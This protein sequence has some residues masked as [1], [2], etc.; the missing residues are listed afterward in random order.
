MQVDVIWEESLKK[1]RLI[2]EVSF[3]DNTN[4]KTFDSLKD[5]LDSIKDICSA[6]NFPANPTNPI[7]KDNSN[8]EH[9]KN[10]LK[11][12]NTI[13]KLNLSNNQ[14][15]PEGAIAIAAALKDNKT[16]TTLGLHNNQIGPE[17]AIAI[18]TALKDKAITGLYLGNNQIGD[19][20]AIAIAAA[21]KD[22][23]AITKLGLLNNQIGP[24]GAKAIAAVLK[25]NKTI[26]TLSLGNNKIGDEGAI[27]IA[28]AL[29]DNKIITGLYLYDN[30]IGDEGAKALAAVLKDNKAITK[31][32]LSNNQIGDEGAI[33]IATALKD[34]KTIT[35]LNLERNKIGDKG[36]KALAAALKDNKNIKIIGL[37]I[38]QAKDNQKSKLTSADIK[39]INKLWAN[40][41]IEIAKAAKDAKTAKAFED[42][43][44]KVFRSSSLD[45]N[46]K[47][48]IYKAYNSCKDSL[49]NL[50]IKELT[51]IEKN[52]KYFLAGGFIT[53][54]TTLILIL[55]EIQPRL[56][57][58]DK[59]SLTNTMLK[60]LKSLT[61]KL[62]SAISMNKNLFS[63]AF[64]GLF[65]A[66]SMALFSVSY[67]G[68]KGKE[69]KK[70]AY[71][72]AKDIFDKSLGI[73]SPNLQSLR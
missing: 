6:L 62:G 15:G 34:N 69:N 26:T 12:N 61:E 30:Q 38:D 58:F 28:A 13:T 5:A 44:D 63:L 67:S 40:S 23:K 2:Y 36:E 64:I 42:M 21:L 9:L 25:D 73:D 4:T 54:A 41:I 65:A 33:A 18:A 3:E 51:N 32:S 7:G 50:D 16:I 17:G 10:F 55:S 59:S 52:A 48:D 46:K 22:N 1:Y 29:K 45:E 47:N 60:S 68:F 19:E 27:A 56:E 57:I 53:A 24:E 11:D 14:I 72:P 71:K 66:S 49:K 8:I 70:S 43:I 31:L 37:N 35:T 20:G 39:E